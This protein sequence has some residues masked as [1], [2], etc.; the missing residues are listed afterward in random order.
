MLPFSISSDAWPKF[1]PPLLL[2]CVF[3]VSG[4]KQEQLEQF[5]KQVQE[6]TIDKLPELPTPMKI[7]SVG[8]F[9]LQVDKAIETSKANARIIIV[10]DGRPNVLQLRSYQDIAAEEFP[11][12]LVQV[13]TTATDISQLVGQTLNATVYLSASRYEPIWSCQDQ[14]I[15]SLTIQSVQENVLKGDLRC[16]KLISSQNASSP[17]SGT[18]EAVFSST[19][20]ATSDHGTS[21]DRMVQK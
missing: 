11:S 3:A 17:L 21:V 10:G 9:K 4:C 2:V 14:S 7:V 16:D 18:V 5:A 19:S 8:A 20:V 6:Q 1:V 15:A 13:N 12:V